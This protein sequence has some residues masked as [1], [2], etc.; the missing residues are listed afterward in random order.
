VLD[1]TNKQEFNNYMIND[2]FVYLYLRIIIFCFHEDKQLPFI[3]TMQLNKA[4]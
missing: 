1:D 2:P 4:Y 3:F